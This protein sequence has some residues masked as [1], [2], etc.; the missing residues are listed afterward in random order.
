VLVT[1][2][3]EIHDK[4]AALEEIRS[5][6]KPG[7]FL[8]IT[9]FLLDPH[10]L[11]ARTIMDLAGQVG[12]RLRIKIGSPFTYTVNLERPWASDNGDPRR[13]PGGSS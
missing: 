9:E 11:S 10:Y 3:G 7:G 5:S 4:L 1:V 13:G 6:L 2:L 8:S 12:L